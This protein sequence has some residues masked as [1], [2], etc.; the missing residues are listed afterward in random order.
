VEE[1]LPLT[2]SDERRLSDQVLVVRRPHGPCSSDRSFWRQTPILEADSLEN[3]RRLSA[4]RR[5]TLYDHQECGQPTTPMHRDARPLALHGIRAATH[6]STPGIHHACVSAL[7]P[8]PA[9][10]RSLVRSSSRARPDTGARWGWCLG[11][12]RVAFVDRESSLNPCFCF[13]YWQPPGTTATSQAAAASGTPSPTICSLVSSLLHACARPWSA[14]C[15][16]A[17]PC[18]HACIGSGCTPGCHA[19]SWV[20]DTFFE[21]STVQV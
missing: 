16:A 14:A 13:C 2:A 21:T 8:L 7:H 19:Q 3:R 9:A 12:C 18:M 1:L 15:E 20:H 17:Q 4:K 10:G 11:C 6:T 5:I